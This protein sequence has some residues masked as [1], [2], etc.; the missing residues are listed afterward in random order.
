MYSGDLP[1]DQEFRA[2][3]GSTVPLNWPV[4]GKKI[5]G[6][7]PSLAVNPDAGVEVNPL[8]TG[9]GRLIPTTS[10]DQFF[11]EMALWLGVPKSSLPLVLPN[12]GNFY[13]AGSSD[14]PLG[15]LL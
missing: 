1:G 10:V 4:K 6:Q 9:R 11:A 15:Y 13:S 14:P 8:D 12:I 3:G 7:F 5:Y 2:P